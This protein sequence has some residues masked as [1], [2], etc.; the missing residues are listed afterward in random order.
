MIY[1]GIRSLIFVVHSFVLGWTQFYLPLYAVHT[2]SG[3]GPI[4]VCILNYFLNGVKINLNQVKGILIAFIGI[5]LTVNG[6]VIWSW[7]NPDYHFETDFKNYKT[8]D[9]TTLFL[10]ALTFFVNMMFWAYA[11]LLTKKNDS[12][13]VAI[14][15]HQAVM[16]LIISGVSYTLLP[17]HVTAEA[18]YPSILY[19]GCVIGG[20][21]TI[22]NIGLHICSNTSVAS[23]LTQGTVLVAYG[24][25]LFRYG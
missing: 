12:H 5:I 13:I 10:V 20:G 23:L 25:S 21:F 18:Y 3:F 8:N 11:I 4:F 24:F 14:V 17:I 1:L 7:M 16:G 6:K 9:P 15:Y 22:F 2:I 19:S